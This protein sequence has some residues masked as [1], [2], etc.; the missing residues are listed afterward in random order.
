MATLEKEYPE[1]TLLYNTH[2]GETNDHDALSVSGGVYISRDTPDGTC[3]AGDICM[4]IEVQI[5]EGD[6]Y[7]QSS[8]AFFQSSSLTSQCSCCPVSDNRT[9]TL[10]QTTI[11]L[12][13]SVI[14]Q[15]SA[16]YTFFFVST[17][18]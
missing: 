16:T 14:K 3:I 12:A 15:V 10:T 8:G 9:D 18:R 6:D 13:E 2:D 11:R 1:L 5:A 4:P 17:L 7:L